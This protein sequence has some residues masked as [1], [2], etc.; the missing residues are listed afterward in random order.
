MAFL[1]FSL[2]LLLLSQQ[3]RPHQE[4]C[5]LLGVLFYFHS[6]SLFSLSF[7]A[8]K[9]VCSPSS[10]DRRFRGLPGLGFG[11][12]LVAASFDSLFLLLACPLVSRVISFIY[13]VRVR[14][15]GGLDV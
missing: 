5:L 13:F 12:G 14:W 3:A 10:I 6:L 9:K 15:G 11:V 1:S 2:C 8:M 4:A 7:V